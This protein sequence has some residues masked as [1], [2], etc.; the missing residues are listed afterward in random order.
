MENLGEKSTPIQGSVLFG[1]VSGAIG[2]YSLP[3]HFFLLT[4]SF[5][6]T[7]RSDSSRLLQF[8]TGCSESIDQ[9]SEISGED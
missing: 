3:L 5:Y 9:S 8:P 6:R 1:T 2:M 7:R 4:I